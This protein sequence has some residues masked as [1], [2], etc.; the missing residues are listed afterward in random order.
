MTLELK[1]QGVEGIQL[2]PSFMYVI[3]RGDEIGVVRDLDTKD[4]KNLQE[5]LDERDL[6]KFLQDKTPVQLKRL[7]VVGKVREDAKVSRHHGILAYDSK[8]SRWDYHDISRNG[9][10][11]VRF[12]P[13]DTPDHESGNTIIGEAYYLTGSGGDNKL[14]QYRVEKDAAGK[15]LLRKIKEYDARSQEAIITVIGLPNPDPSNKGIAVTTL[16][17][18]TAA[19][20]FAPRLKRF[21]DT[22]DRK[23]EGV[24]QLT[25]DRGLQVELTEVISTLPKGHPSR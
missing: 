2:D 18:T 24:Y 13:Q 20:S 8:N 1:I 3:G 10:L 9:S 7:S 22:F 14:Y 16:G 21:Q 4:I 19:I 11:V 6:S 12:Y 17:T 23:F 5:I 15:T 25:E